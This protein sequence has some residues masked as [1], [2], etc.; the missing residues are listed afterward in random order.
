MMR[1]TSALTLGIC[2]CFAVSLSA[3]TFDVQRD[4]DGVTVKL[5]GKLLTR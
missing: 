4:A 3:A 1:A 2:W 5:N